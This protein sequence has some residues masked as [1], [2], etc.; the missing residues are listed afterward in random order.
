MAI[1]FRT[2][3]L[4]DPSGF[5]LALI[6]VPQL[7]PET[8]LSVMDKS[9]LWEENISSSD[10]G[11]V[12]SFVSS[13]G[14]MPSVTSPHFLVTNVTVKS[15]ND[16][17]LAPLYYK[18]VCRFY[19]Y[20]FGDNPIKQVYITD[21]EGNILKGINY[22]V[23]AQRVAKFVYKITVYTDFVSGSVV[24]SVKYNRCSVTGTSIFPSW[25][26]VL[27]PRSAFVEGV[28]FVAA[29]QYLLLGPD[30]NG[31][32]NAAV[33]EIPT[34]TPITNT[35]GVSF[36]IAPTFLDNSIENI[37]TYTEGVS[38]TYTIR[39][40]SNSTFTIF[41][42][43][44]RAGVPANNYLTSAT[45]DSWGSA[46]NFNAG[47][48]ITGI[49]G[50]ELYVGN[51]NP[52]VPNDTAFF[53]VSKAKFYLAL[54]SYASI[55]LAKP[56]GKGPKDDWYLRVRNGRFR[57]RFNSDGTEAIHE[58]GT[59]WEY[60]IPEYDA[61]LFNDIYG[62]PY[63]DSINE[64][65]TILDKNTIQLQNVPLY[66]DPSSVLMNPDFPGF[67]PTGII[68]IDLNESTLSEDHLLDW[69][70]Q[71]GTVELSN[72][73]T[74][75]DQLSVTYIYEDKF[76]EYSGFLGSGSVYPSEEPFPFD[77][78]NLN[79][80]PDLGYGIYAS[81]L[82]AHIFARPSLNVTTGESVNSEKVLYHNFTGVSETDRVT[83]AETV[84]LAH[85]SG[86]DDQQV[87][88]A[89]TGQEALFDGGAELDSAQYAFRPSSVYFDGLNSFITFP[90][91][92]AKPWGFW[93]DN[94]S[95]EFKFRF[96]T[97]TNQ[98][99]FLGQ[100]SSINNH[101]Y[102]YKTSSASG[103]KLGMKFVYDGVTVADYVMQS[104]SSLLVNTWHTL[105]FG[106][107]G[108]TGVI[109]IDGVP[110]TLTETVAFGS[111]NTGHFPMPLSIGDSGGGPI[112]G[113]LD[114]LF[115]VHGTILH[116]GYYI[117]SSSYYRYGQVDF[118]I[119]TVAIG[120]NC[121]IEDITVIDA[122]TRGGGL[123]KLGINN[124]D[125]V[126]AVQPEAQFY[127]DIG[128]FDGQAVPADGVIVVNIPKTI[129]VANGGAFKEDEVRQKVNKHLAY[130]SYAIIQYY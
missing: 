54:T 43:K 130:G 27:N 121:K 118:E 95:I 41:R 105:F 11:V 128:Y 76:Y 112:N 1:G 98:Q 60:S 40:T 26:E 79:P 69:D 86:P 82:V 25:T 56:L 38:V 50:V 51:D 29:D 66:I 16:M 59:L 53:N 117:P 31:L 33:P 48:T 61:S 65:P 24:Y 62:K 92:P 52:L 42:D 127:W 46:T 35:V 8:N 71:N 81:G 97:L 36:D 2:G 68:S 15:S 88:T 75:R 119:G 102:V 99:H 49:P 124:I 100:Y 67:P 85:F 80:S 109:I 126:I 34:I 90:Y 120:P 19:H 104:S 107:N 74:S 125:K 123:S 20:S 39:A 7:D 3:R 23:K 30:G 47:V 115:I 57:K 13:N 83:N 108:T 22:Y 91:N 96:E 55:Y 93:T 45:S 37:E 58:E 10:T 9:Y 84:L 122:R 4:V 129:L 44:T 72:N 78:L 73:L 103:N 110:Q 18:Y 89:D 77:E 17:S 106:R 94:F 21:Q 113:W 111:N 116:T 64:R 6:N 32:Y 14:L 63:R 114:E 5:P 101:W 70:V 87:Y 28:P 12:S